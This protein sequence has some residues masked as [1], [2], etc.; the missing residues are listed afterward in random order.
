MNRLFLRNGK[1]ASLTVAS[2]SSV[3]VFAVNFIAKRIL[4]CFFPS[5]VKSNQSV[6]KNSENVEV[7]KKKIVDK[8]KTSLSE[9]IINYSNS[10]EF[11]KPFTY[12]HETFDK[13]LLTTIKN[14]SD[15][16]KNIGY[17]VV[18]ENANDVRAVIDERKI[19][20]IRTAIFLAIVI[21][22]FSYVLNR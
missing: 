14:V 7:I 20:I 12:T 13:F 15:G 11:G 22:I 5:R 4:P 21:F 2:V 6:N 17:L 8:K 19:F 16:K 1:Y 3:F 18:T 9:I 10:K